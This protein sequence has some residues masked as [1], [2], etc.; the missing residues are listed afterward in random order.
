MNLWVK[1]FHDS[2]YDVTLSEENMWQR[3]S[4]A[5]NWG[6]F[7]ERIAQLNENRQRPGGVE[8]LREDADGQERAYYQYQI[9][10]TIY[11]KR[12]GD[13]EADDLHIVLNYPTRL[14]KSRDP[15]ASMFG[16]DFF[17]SRSPFGG[18][19]TSPFRSSTLSIADSRPVVAD[20]TVA[21]IRVKPIP[22]AGRPSD[23]RGAVGQ[24]QIE[25]QAL[26][27]SV[28]AGDPITLHLGIRGDGPM[29]LVQA[30][31]LAELPQLTAD[32]KVANEPLAGIVKGDVKL[33]STTIRPRREGVAQIPAIPLTYFD[34]STEQFVTVHS[35]PISIQVDPAERLA[36]DAIV[37]TSNGRTSSEDASAAPPTFDLT[38]YDGQDALTH[39][40]SA[41]RWPWFLIAL[42][43]PL[44]VGVAWLMRRR[45]NF[46]ASL[47]GGGSLRF[48]GIRQ[49]IEAASS[50]SE[51]S[52][53]LRNLRPEFSL[54]QSQRLQLDSLLDHCDH[55]AYGA[56]QDQ[57][58]PALKSHATRL[59]NEWSAVAAQPSPTRSTYA[60]PSRRTLAAA[61]LASAVVAVAVPALIRYANDDRMTAESKPSRSVGDSTLSMP[62][63]TS[64]QRQVLLSE[65]NS[66]YQNGLKASDDDAADANEEFAIAAVKYAQLIKNGVRNP[67]LFVNL[68]NAQLQLG[69]TGKA[70]ANF[71]RALALNPANRQAR[72]NLAAA[73]AAI[74]PLPD[75][76][77]STSLAAWRRSISETMQSL[78][79]PIVASALVAIAWGGLWLIGF[80]CIA[81]SS[82]AWKTA[83]IPAA[84]LLL[85]AF[86]VASPNWFVDDASRAIVAVPSASL[87]E[88]PGE[89]FPKIASAELN[90][91]EAIQVLQIDGK[92][93]QVQ[94][95]NGSTGWIAQP[96]V[97]IL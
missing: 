19:R 64:E 84:C 78:V 77:N 38:N 45:Q 2:E 83:L 53:A 73:K 85:V 70:I 44:T 90:E 21:P 34:P 65:A 18:M 6:A 4:N 95:A 94:A 33:F 14:A 92:W 23:Y 27:T 89:Q 58:L 69:F 48:R 11:P 28:K 10:A 24:Y 32:F 3:I 66:A 80:G 86:A 36:L 56:A 26:P 63:L 41:R 13:I 7:S 82:R 20:A 61:C 46:F 93:L 9:E 75:E 12:P 87:R 79:S 42:C 96:E 88:A 52:T 67:R 97:E 1:P 72:Q 68:G 40:A 37:G 16:D 31:P 54:D 50:P 49:T 35:D 5:T 71:D 30:P 62:S 60:W 76:A 59:L 55:A 39:V 43:P 91:G 47:I 51:L 25:T 17:G 8:V 81:S 74:S 57:Q 22:T 15:F 29:A